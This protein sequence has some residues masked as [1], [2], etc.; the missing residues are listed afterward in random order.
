MP[1]NQFV[2]F[3]SNE[4]HQAIQRTAAAAGQAMGAWIRAT[5]LAAV[6]D[7]TPEPDVREPGRPGAKKTE[8][9]N[10]RTG[11]GFLTAKDYAAGRIACLNRAEGGPHCRPGW[12]DRA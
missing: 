8:A 1:R 9:T 10:R 3:L 2:I 6:D 5:C 12:C 4:E 7:V 11:C